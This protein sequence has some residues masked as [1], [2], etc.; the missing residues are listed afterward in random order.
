MSRN[1]VLGIVLRCR[2]GDVAP[3]D[4]RIRRDTMRRFG[5]GLAIAL[6]CL[7]PG[8]TA[9]GQQTPPPPPAAGDVTP[10]PW[11]KTAK[12]GGVT[13]GIYEP[14]LDSWNYYEYAAHAAVSVLAA[15]A[16]EPVFGVIWVTARSLVDRQNRSVEL[17]GLAVTKVNF[18]SAPAEAVQYQKDFQALLTKKT[19]TLPLDR[20]KSQLAIEGAEK[21]AKAVPVKNDP[22]RFVFSDKPAVLVLVDGD[23][24]WV[25][26]K[27]SSLQRVLNTRALVLSDT[28][29]NFYVHV[30]DGF[31]TAASLLGPWTAAPVVPAGAAEAAETLGK[32][33]VVDLMRGEPDSK[34]KK[35]PSLRNGAPAIVVATTPTELIVT[36]GPFDWVPIAGTKLLYLENTTGNVFKDLD[37]QRTYV[38]VTG[39]WFRS[40][41]LSGPWAYVKGKDLPT[42]FAMIPDDSPKENVKASVP[43]T[44]Q[45]AELIIANE[46]PQTAVIYRTKLSFT[47]KISG[48]PEIKPIPDTSMSWV[49][50][51]PAPIIKVDD[52]DWFACSGGVWFAASAL[53]GPWTVAAYV[54][55][56]VYTIPPSS[57]LYY[58]TFVHVYSSTATTVV[59]AYTPGYTGTV[60][61]ADGVVV[62]GTGYVYPSYVSSTVWY[63]A[64]VTYGY[65]ANPT[66]TPWTGWALGFG[67]GFALAAS[68]AGYHWGGCWGCAPYWGAMPYAYR[69]YGYYGYHGAAYGP[70]GGAAA[71]GP[72]GWAATSGNIYHQYGA[73]S[74]VSR[75]SAGYNAWTGNAWSSKVGTSYNSV[76]GRMSAGQ[77]AS[78][79][80]VYTG[81]YGY[82]SRGATYNPSTGVAA[83]GGRAT[84]GNA[85]TGQQTTIGHATVSGPGGRSAHVQQVGN[86]YYAERDGNVYRDT[87]T[88]FQQ[89]GSNGS[90]NNVSRDA[91]NQS[92]ANQSAARMAGDQR[93]AA[94]SWGGGSGWDG[95]TKYLGSEEGRGGGG[96]SGAGGGGGRSWSGGGW[97]GGSRWGGGGGGGRSFSGGGVG[98]G[99]FGGGGFGGFRGGRR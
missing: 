98:G 8:W 38:L 90:W 28:L 41:E 43:G 71:W 94:S 47:A 57:P 74:A 89:Y 87:G 56:V 61:S 93:T 40:L 95:G 29:G 51:S 86:N 81:G 15:G 44:A 17:V 11:P 20:L 64:P 85:Y 24:V 54:P 88:G 5:M 79:S 10:D 75:S 25:P 84:V 53:A 6:L 70:Y 22:P 12:L 23:P 35:W 62:Y 80:N 52:N 9:L 66:W 91:T 59:V 14:Q 13:Y 33:N 76:T 73:T 21:K 18:P 32:E 55:A 63:P 3:E 45:A 27:G 7:G 78:V 4:P 34:T 46:I 99:R 31:E 1:S 26:V 19:A 49:V 72:G 83:A 60:V 30:L 2:W 69:G 65:A 36:R 42:D 39:R 58:V 82:G 97:G 37:D 16:K 67:F 48:P 92:L 50:N 77:S 68:T 96:A